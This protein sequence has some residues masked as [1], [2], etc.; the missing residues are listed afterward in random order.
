MPLLREALEEVEKFSAA[1][2]PSVLE[3]SLLLPWSEGDRPQGWGSGPESL[4]IL[5]PHSASSRPPRLWAASPEG[6]S[7]IQGAG[8]G[9][10]LLETPAPNSLSPASERSSCYQI[11]RW[12]FHDGI[13][14]SSTLKMNRSQEAFCIF[15]CWE[16]TAAQRGALGSRSV[17]L[18]TLPLREGGLTPL[19]LPTAPGER[20]PLLEVSRAA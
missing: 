1:S 19:S 7:T 9:G 6:S 16:V 18:I 3:A 5:C 17:L 15:K 4:V 13:I 12:H 20:P 8:G 10:V 14:S 2:L 11:T